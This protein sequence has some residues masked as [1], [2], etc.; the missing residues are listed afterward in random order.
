MAAPSVVAVAMRNPGAR[1]RLRIIKP[2]INLWEMDTG[3][4]KSNVHELYV[5]GGNERVCVVAYA[6]LLTHEVSFVH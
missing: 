4:G 2:E 5:V 3:L 1:A 6:F